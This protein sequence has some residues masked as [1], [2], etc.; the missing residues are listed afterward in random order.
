MSVQTE[1][2]GEEDCQSVNNDSCF[3]FFIEFVREKLDSHVYVDPNITS[4]T[5]T[6]FLMLGNWW[7]L[8][9]V[10]NSS[11]EGLTAKPPTVTTPRVHVTDQKASLSTS[12]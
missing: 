8:T 9:S 4:M 5:T 7:V 6:T 3:F 12:L 2:N 11:V 10:Q 1:D